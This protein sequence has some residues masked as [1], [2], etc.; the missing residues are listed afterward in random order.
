[1]G[2]IVYKGEGTESMSWKTFTPG[3]SL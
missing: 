1:M 2:D 3:T